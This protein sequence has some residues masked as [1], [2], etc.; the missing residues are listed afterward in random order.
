MKKGEEDFM[1]H[2]AEDFLL[3]TIIPWDL[4]R[5]DTDVFC[6]SV[7]RLIKVWIFRGGGS[8]FYFMEQICRVDSANIYIIEEE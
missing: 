2:L 3:V 5:V 6:N 1:E 8:Y 7:L 4:K